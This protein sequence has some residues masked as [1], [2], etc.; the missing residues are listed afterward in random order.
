MYS[1]R[2]EKKTC[3]CML[4]TSILGVPAYGVHGVHMGLAQN[5][6]HKKTAYT[7]TMLSEP[8]TLPT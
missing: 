1:D 8:L 5:N 2:L 6:N 4:L 3:C 7:L